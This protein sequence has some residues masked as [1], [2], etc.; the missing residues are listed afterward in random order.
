MKAK[1][2]ILSFFFLCGLFSNHLNA[3]PVLIGNDSLSGVTLND[4]DLKAVLLGKTVSLNGKRVVIIIAKSSDG[5]DEFLKSKAGKTISQFQSHWRRLFMTGAG[6]APTTVKDQSELI[7]TVSAT[8][9]AIG[10]VDD[11]VA[12]ELPILAQ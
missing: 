9:G 10:I 1:K 8:S 12:T 3:A 5:Q 4:S 11:S 7:S 6:A 2:L